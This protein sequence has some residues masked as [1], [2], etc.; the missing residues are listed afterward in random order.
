MFFK[1]VD[2]Q[3][4]LRSVDTS[5]VRLRLD[6]GSISVDCRRYIGRHF[7]Y[8]VYIVLVL[9]KYSEMS[10]ESSSIHNKFQSF[11]LLEYLTVVSTI[12]RSWVTVVSLAALF[13]VSSRNQ[14]RPFYESVT[15]ACGQRPPTAGAYPCFCSMK[16][17]IVLLLQPR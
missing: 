13:V 2:R 15:C 14:K 10:D 1:L 16:Q 12:F 7:W 8:I 6:V 5:T 4:P 11:S 9:L 17:L 3:S